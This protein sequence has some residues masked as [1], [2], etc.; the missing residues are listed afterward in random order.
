MTARGMPMEKTLDG[1]I[2]RQRQVLGVVVSNT[3]L[4]GY[5][6]GENIGW[7]NLSP[8]NGGVLNDGAGNLSGYAWGEN[9]GWI[10]FN[11]VKIN[12]STGAFSGYAWGE[13]IG[14]INFNVSFAVV[15]SWKPE[16]TTPPFTSVRFTPDPNAAGW[17]NSDVQVEMAGFDNQG[18]SG[19]KSITYSASGAQ[20]I[21][22]TTVYGSSTSFSIV[23]EGYTTLIFNTTDNAGNSET[24]RTLPVYVDKTPPAIQLTC[25]TTLKLNETGTAIVMVTDSL[26]GV[27]GQSVQNGP[28]S[29]DS[30]T[31]NLH[32]FTVT[33]TDKA[34][35]G[36]SQS[37]TYQ[38]VYDFI[39][40]GGFQPPL[41]DPSKL[42]KVKAGSTVPLK[43]QL[44]DGH[45]GFISDVGVVTSIKT[46][47]FNCNIPSAFIGSAVELIGSTNR[48][49]LRY[50][51]E[52]NQF[53]YNWQTSSSWK[54]TCRAVILTLNDGSTYRANFSF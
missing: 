6:W 45:G 22:T 47:Q 31:V 53:V 29:L 51:A 17:N 14:W 28:N 4:T 20:T 18:G 43:W 12:P 37:C 48:A 44:P 32:T 5:A 52:K 13:N 40:T 41:G 7:I 25:P 23:N 8:T 15:T 33:A 1:S 42:N 27:W 30:S 16:D 2:S 24:P 9:I 36:S 11:G 26:S 3:G 46:Q 38:V 10:N 35:N 19:V 21:P 34:D 49:G 39:G 54:G 50:D